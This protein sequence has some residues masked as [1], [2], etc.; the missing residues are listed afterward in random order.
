MKVTGLLVLILFLVG[1]SDVGD[2]PTPARTGN[3]ETTVQAAVASALPTETPIPTPDIDATVQAAVASALPTETAIPTPDIDATVQAAVAAALPTETPTPTATATSINIP[4]PA[5]TPTPVP[6]HT[7][8]P[9]HTPTPVPPHTPTPTHTPTPVPTPTPTPT[10][11]PTPMQADALELVV[12]EMVKQ[13]RPAVVRISSGS[14]TG[15]GVIFDAPGQTGYV[16]TNYHVVEGRTLVDVTVRDAVTYSGRVLG[17]DTDRDLAVL[18]ICCGNFTSLAFGDA[19]TLD[20]GDEVVSI[21]YALAIQGS[22]TVTKGI[23]SAVRYDPAY[24]AKV[25]QSDAPINPGNSGGPVLSLDGLVLGI[26][27]FKLGEAL[28]FAISAE[29]VLERIPVLRAGT[30]LPIPTPTTRPSSDDSWGPRSGE[31]V[32]DPASNFIKSEYAEVWIEDMVAEATFVNPYGASENPWDY[33]FILRRSSEDEPF[34]QFVVSS[35]SRWAVWSG[36]DAPY[37]QIA[38]G[39]VSGLE[40]GAGGRSQLMVVAIGGRGWLFVNGELMTA[41][42]LSSAEQRGDVAVITGAYIGDEVAGASTRF[43]DFGGYGLKR[44]YGPSDGSIEKEEEDAISHHPSGVWTRDA[45]VEASFVNPPGEDWDYGFLIRNPEFNRAE[46][47]TFNYNASWFH[48]AIDVGD[49]EHTTLASGQVSASLTTSPKR[50]HL[51]LMAIGEDGWLFINDELLS[52]LDLDHNLDEGS[53]SIIAN[54]WIGHRA[55]VEYR[56]FS[57]WAP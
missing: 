5:P 18:S 8:T 9:T 19:S 15:T 51:L 49:H 54:S 6:P 52:K 56:D 27:T 26:N 48:N 20:P 47:V 43:E 22:A 50:N 40:T 33:G 36:A 45:I 32:H 2:A 44:R 57:V 7:P 53:V 42:D 41:V 14:A 25:I 38:G 31:L 12:S 17:V 28:G 11:T 10:H 1:C 29:T 21:G 16:V 39:T 35:N 3:L 13:V 30:A 37:E 34:L 23:V 4:T 24:R 46:I 55:E